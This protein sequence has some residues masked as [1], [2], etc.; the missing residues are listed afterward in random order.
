MPARAAQ[1]I[2]A[3]RRHQIGANQPRVVRYRVECSQ[4][5]LGAIAKANR[6]RAIRSHHRRIGQPHEEIVGWQIVTQSV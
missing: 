4:A 1:Q 2:G 6:Q 3:H 5:R